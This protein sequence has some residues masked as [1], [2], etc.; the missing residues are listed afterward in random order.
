MGS[1]LELAPCGTVSAYNRHRRHSETPCEP[2]FAANR[3]YQQQRRDRTR[4][5]RQPRETS[6][7]S[8]EHAKRQIRAGI[9][10]QSGLPART[11][12]RELGCTTRQVITD[13]EA[14][15]V[16]I[17]RHRQPKPA[18]GQIGAGEHC[19]TERGY[20]AHRHRKEPAC[21]PCL[22]AHRKTESDRAW[23]KRNTT[24][25]CAGSGNPPQRDAGPGPQH[26][27]TGICVE[28]GSIQQVRRD[29]TIRRHI[30]ARAQGV[31]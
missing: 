19:G 18:N 29:G 5:T 25:P 15:G 14:M 30:P 8:D 9:L 11:I 20:Q 7:H 4:P 27:P 6:T 22:A 10:A 17:I 23:A 16:T 26:Q 2:C 3:E 28:C 24:P 31:A 13:L 1:K 12:A 21:E